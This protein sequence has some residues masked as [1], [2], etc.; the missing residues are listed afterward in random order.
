M[1]FPG[2]KPAYRDAFGIRPA[3]LHPDSRGDVTLRS[4]DPR[5]HVRIRFNPFS[6]PNDLP[7][8]REGIKRGREI[9]LQKAMDPFSST[10]L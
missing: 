1:W 3:I 4:T 9:A 10:A 5:E 8:L 2:I 7:T 6:A